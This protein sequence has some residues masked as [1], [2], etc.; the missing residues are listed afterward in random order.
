[1]PYIKLISRRICQYSILK[2][3]EALPKLLTINGK[4]YPT[5]N[6][7]TNV[8]QSILN[9]TNRNLHLN[10]NHP[11]GILRTIIETKLNSLSPYKTFNNFSPIVTKW[12]NFDSLG[13]PPTHP[14]RSKSDTYYIN[15]TTLLRTHTSAH[16]IEC[17]QDINDDSGHNWR[18]FLISADVYRRDEI[19]KT[20]YPVLYQMEGSHLWTRPRETSNMEA[21]IKSLQSTLNEMLINNKMTLTR[22]QDEVEP[23]TETRQDYMTEQETKLCEMHLKTTL[24]IVVLELCRLKNMKDVKMRWTNTTFPWTQPSWEIEIWWDNQ[25]LEICGCGII[26]QDLLLKSDFEKDS[27]IG[28]AF[29]LG[30]DRIAMLLFGIPDIRLLWSNDKRFIGQFVEGQIN[31][32]K[33]YSKYPGT[34]RDVAFWLPDI[35]QDNEEIHE[36]DVMEIVRD[37]AG[38]LVESVKLTDEFIHPKTHKRS[39]CYRI[40]YQSMDRN[41]TNSEIN[42]LQEKVR[43]ELVKKYHVEL[44]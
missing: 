5:S 34:L 24:E 23:P 22:C 35:L 6:K 7:D 27:T 9:L 25:W 2:T 33:P 11:I 29:G 1:M 42:S 38:D 40:N 8:T 14:G 31:T 15:D 18:G 28:W 13:F 36:N 26:K 16:E 39:L 3:K 43:N 32:F 37:V 21:E 10:P 20:H 44:R 30:L 12:Q 17:F 41:I 4:E 19:D